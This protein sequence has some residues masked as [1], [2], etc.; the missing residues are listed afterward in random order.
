MGYWE[1]LEALK[2]FLGGERAFLISVLSKGESVY[3][4][5]KLEAELAKFQSSESPP[6]PPSAVSLLAQ[7]E[8]D[9]KLL[10]RR[11]AK[12]H[13]GLLLVDIETRRGM[14]FEILSIGEQLEGYWAEIDFYKREGYWPQKAFKI[15]GEAENVK[16]INNLR[17]YI[18]K[19]QNDPAKAHKV[20]DW[21]AELAALINLNI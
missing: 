2:Q 14:A 10:Y 20:K 8:A 11:A 3:N 4:S 17:T 9:W 6:P 15:G 16:R 18:C 12:L 21:E 13:A 5:Q 19:W 7:K 1:K